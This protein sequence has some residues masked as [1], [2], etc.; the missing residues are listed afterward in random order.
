[1]NR[2]NALNPTGIM[3]TGNCEDKTT[4]FDLIII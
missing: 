4:P 3:Q 2:K 1:M